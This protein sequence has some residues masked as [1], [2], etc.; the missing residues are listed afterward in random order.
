MVK[1]DRMLRQRWTSLKCLSLTCANDLDTPNGPV[2]APNR[3]PGH[4][5]GNHF[6]EHHSTAACI[7]HKR[8]VGH[9]A[10]LLRLTPAGASQPTQTRRPGPDLTFHGR[11]MSPEARSCDGLD[12][13]RSETAIIYFSP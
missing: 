3:T 6:S 4:V 2:N 12:L 11:L 9:R 7:V 8:S 13:C 5:R 1:V 10:A